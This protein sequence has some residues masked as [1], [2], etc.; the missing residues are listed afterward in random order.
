[1]ILTRA[2]LADSTGSLTAVWFNQPFLL[3]TLHPGERYFFRGHL[4]RDWRT[5]PTGGRARTLQLLSPL[6]EKEGR[7]W[8]VYAETAGISSKYL[9]RLIWTALKTITTPDFL[10]EE[11]RRPALIKIHFPKTNADIIAARQRFALEEFYL[12]ALKML[13]IREGLVRLS[14]PPLVVS[15]TFLKKFWRTLLCLNRSPAPGHGRDPD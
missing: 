14:A 4:E 8:A 11:V 7:I 2:V 15:D 12:F 3:K 5:S 9:G 1:M 13:K 6:Y 10:P